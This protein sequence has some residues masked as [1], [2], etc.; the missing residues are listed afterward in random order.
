MDIPIR[1]DRFEATTRSSGISEDALKP[2]EYTPS[3]KVASY[4][5]LITCLRQL[6]LL[7]N[8]IVC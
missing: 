4:K 7:C 6:G 1:E 3:S 5:L 2:S 8:I